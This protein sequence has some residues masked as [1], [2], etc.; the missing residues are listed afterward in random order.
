MLA[1]ARARPAAP[2][3]LLFPPWAPRPFL[4]NLWRF[5]LPAARSGKRCN[6]RRGKRTWTSTSRA[7]CVNPMLRIISIVSSMP[8]C[9][10]A[11]GR[12]GAASSRGRQNQIE[13]EIV[14]CDSRQSSK[15]LPA[16]RPQALPT[17][18]HRHTEAGMARPPE[19]A[20]SHGGEQAAEDVSELERRLEHAVM[21]QGDYES[22]L[23]KLSAAL[24]SERQSK[25]ENSLLAHELRA[26]IQDLHCANKELVDQVEHW[27]TRAEQAL[28]QKAV[29]AMNGD[30]QRSGKTSA[31]AEILLDIKKLQ[32][33][34]AYW[35]QQAKA[36]VNEYEQAEGDVRRLLRELQHSREALK[37][38]DEQERVLR[39]EIEHLHQT[40]RSVHSLH[41][42]VSS[43]WSIV[44]SRCS[45]RPSVRIA[46]DGEALTRDD[47]DLPKPRIAGLPAPPR[48]GTDAGRNAEDGSAE[49]CSS[50]T[51]T[52]LTTLDA[53]PALAQAAAGMQHAPK[54]GAGATAA[55]AA[56]AGTAVLGNGLVQQWTGA[57]GSLVDVVSSSA[58]AI[59]CAG[60]ALATV[61]AWSA[62]MAGSN[63]ECDARDA[64]PAYD[65]IVQKQMEML[66]RGQFEEAEKLSLSFSSDLEAAARTCNVTGDLDVHAP[67][68]EARGRNNTESKSGLD[69]NRSTKVSIG[70]N[71]AVPAGPVVDPLAQAQPLKS[72]P[73]P[74]GRGIGYSASV[75]SEDWMEVK[76]QG[77]PLREMQNLAA[78]TNPYTALQ[79]PD[80]NK[81]S[82]VPLQPKLTAQW[83]HPTYSALVEGQKEDNGLATS[84]LRP[85]TQILDKQSEDLRDHS[86]APEPIQF[87]P[88]R[89]SSS[90]SHCTPLPLREK[91]ALENKL[92]AVEPLFPSTHASAAFLH[93]PQVVENKGWK[94]HV[95]IAGTKNLPSTKGMKE[96]CCCVSL[97]KASANISSRS[98]HSILHVQ[99]GQNRAPL[100]VVDDALEI[101]AMNRTSLVRVSEASRTA[102]WNETVTLA[103]THPAA[104]HI[105]GAPFPR[106]Q[107]LESEKLDGGPTLLFVTIHMIDGRDTQ[108]VGRTAV[109]IK[110]EGSHTQSFT[111]LHRDGT[112]VMHNSGT[113]ASIHMRYSYCHSANDGE[114]AALDADNAAEIPQSNAAFAKSKVVQQGPQISAT[115]GYF[116]ASSGH[117]SE[118]TSRTSSAAADN[119]DTSAAEGSHKGSLGLES[120]QPSFVHDQGLHK[121]GTLPKSALKHLK[122]AHVVRQ[123]SSTT[124]TAKSRVGIGISF[125]VTKS[126]DVF[127]TALS[128]GGPAKASG[129]IAEG[130]QLLSVDGCEI[131][132][133]PIKDIVQLILGKA[134]TKVRLDLLPNV[135]DSPLRSGDKAAS[136]KAEDVTPTSVTRK[137]WAPDNSPV[138][139][140]PTGDEMKQAPQVSQA[141]QAHTSQEIETSTSQVA[142]AELEN[143]MTQAQWAR[144]QLAKMG[145][146]FTKQVPLTKG[147][148]PRAGNQAGMDRLNFL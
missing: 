147:Q 77:Y 7:M 13:D 69:E 72:I 97:L 116:S 48:A 35:R 10:P 108:Q 60:S 38:K 65:K 128:Q 59:N 4:S 138:P 47:A 32:E 133:F 110:K 68:I 70:G 56:W 44:E 49:L 148:Q 91:L 21:M 113:P 51:R 84:P 140:S 122:V 127:I 15:L 103:K 79:H 76:K 18:P 33:S 92:A 16:P 9:E 37:S 123:S 87:I 117:T 20:R 81:S 78:H 58:S 86:L 25:G 121:Q 41:N 93:A 89:P 52:W 66:R 75:H 129:K 135:P 11:R 112:P 100:A 145:D 101:S 126:G 99:A 98:F 31:T 62:S 28:E 8:A 40:L 29:D 106:A 124:K 94:M 73:K 46:H 132:G 141:L 74:L 109:L 143:G 118:S 23:Q 96:C 50:H 27:R 55:P 17:T 19:D 134:G 45:N 139:T 115:L 39:E 111:L 85:Q 142:N 64:P 43:E 61:P 136:G 1:C 26:E 12:P 14:L 131:K 146:G 5:P 90:A 125:G 82:F 104:V 24:Q 83:Q 80:S 34:E 71:A 53:P 105:E 22:Q 107:D 36:M 88:S 119:F 6:A 130:D 30:P 95:T 67:N 102:E 2:C 57:S 114:G 3:A 137:L 63:I 42:S 144:M 54:Q 120:L